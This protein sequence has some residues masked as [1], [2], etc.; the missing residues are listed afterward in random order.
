MLVMLEDGD[1]SEVELIG[2]EG[3]AGMPLL[4][5]AE[6]SPL[7]GLM[8]AGGRA[9]RRA[10]EPFRHAL[11]SWSFLRGLLLPY[12]QTSS[13]RWPRPPPATATSRSPG[14]QFFETPHCR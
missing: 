6:E 4:L 14:L 13:P 9:L 10:A 5:K 7:E 3:M 11:H 8:Q 1:V 2:R 12:C